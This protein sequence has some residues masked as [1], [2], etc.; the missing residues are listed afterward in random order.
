MQSLKFFA[1][2]SDGLSSNPQQPLVFIVVL[3]TVEITLKG[4]G[5]VV[6]NTN[7]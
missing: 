3:P 7:I 5:S 2:R 4:I 1:T 6:L